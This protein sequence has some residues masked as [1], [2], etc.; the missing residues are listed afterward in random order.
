MAAIR[1]HA[2]YAAQPEWFTTAPIGAVN[3]VL[4]QARWTKA[5]VDLFEINEAFAV[6]TMAAIRELGLSHD[7]VNIHGG[8]CALGH[9]IGASGARIVVSL[10]N[11]LAKH[12]L[13]RA[14]RLY[15]SAAGKQLQ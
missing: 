13:K 9:P 2:T 12:D 7:E 6:V 11:A 5:G 14:S 1:A 10:L 3:K 8:A 4:E 15:V